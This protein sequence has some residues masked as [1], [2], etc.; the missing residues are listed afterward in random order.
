MPRSI[1]SDESTLLVDETHNTTPTNYLK[2]HQGSLGTYQRCREIFQTKKM[3]VV[4][5]ETKY[6]FPSTECSAKI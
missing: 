5:E 1:K 2:I 3:T 4:F 6:L